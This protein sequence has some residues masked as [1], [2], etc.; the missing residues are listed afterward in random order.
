MMSFMLVNEMSK[1]LIGYR[2]DRIM[3]QPNS[4]IQNAQLNV[5]SVHFDS[6]LGTARNILCCNEFVM[7]YKCKYELPNKSPQFTFHENI[8]RINQR[9]IYAKLW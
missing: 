8:I 1:Q 5:N 7:K 4:K 3:A 6:N 9:T 2:T